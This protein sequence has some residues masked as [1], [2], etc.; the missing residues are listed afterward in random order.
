MHAYNIQIGGSAPPEGWHPSPLED[1]YAVAAY[2]RGST[3]PPSRIVVRR[4]LINW[5]TFDL[6]KH[7]QAQAGQLHARVSRAEY[8]SRKPISQYGQEI[9]FLEGVALVRGSRL[10]ST[11]P[12]ANGR[13]LLIELLFSAPPD[14]YEIVKP[15]F[16]YFLKKLKVTE[17][18]D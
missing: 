16:V 11:V 4:R 15:D 6:E 2:V 3:D 5:P 8:V 1:P 12:T 10:Y 13:W 17:D 7:A 18:E 14:Q 9:E